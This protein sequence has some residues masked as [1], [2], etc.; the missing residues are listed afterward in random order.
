MHISVPAAVNEAVVSAAGD[1]LVAYVAYDTA[2]KLLSSGKFQA[3]DE[4]YKEGRKA[5]AVLFG[6]KAVVCTGVSHGCVIQASIPSPSSLSVSLP[7]NLH[8]TLQS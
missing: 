3:V 4:D 7:D 8:A 1:R 2:I 5:M 6:N